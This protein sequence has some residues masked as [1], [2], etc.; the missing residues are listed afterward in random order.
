[1]P[2]VT[3]QNGLRV[4]NLSSP[5]SFEFDDGTLLPACEP[6]RT[7]ALPVDINEEVF[8]EII[9]GV[10]VDRLK[11][12]L[13]LTPALTAEVNRIQ[14]DDSVDIVIAPL[15]VMEAMKAARMPLGKIRGIRAKDR[16]TKVIFSNRFCV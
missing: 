10:G 12:E 2:V 6:E 9:N 13:Y 8:G 4:G 14:S 5:H 16:I 7:K 3:L 11:L 1:M 15:M